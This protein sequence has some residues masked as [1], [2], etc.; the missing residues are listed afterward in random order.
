[1]QSIRGHRI[2]DIFAV[3]ENIENQIRDSFNI[4][5]KTGNYLKCGEWLIKESYLII[6]VANVLFRFSRKKIPFFAFDYTL[7]GAVKGCIALIRS[8]RYKKRTC[9]EAIR[10]K[11]NVR[12]FYVKGDHPFCVKILVSNIRNIG[13]M[14]TEI[15]TRKRVSE[16]KVL[17]IPKIFRFDLNYSPSFFI[18]E[19]VWGDKPIRGK[20]SGKIEREFS[21][22]IWEMYERYGITAKKIE[23]ILDV[24]K[25][26]EI[27]YKSADKIPWRANYGKKEYFLETAKNILFSNGYLQYSLGH[28]DLTLGN[29]I[30]STE[31]SVYLVDWER[32]RERAIVFDSYEII[33]EIPGSREFFERKLLNYEEN[34][35]NFKFIPFKDQLKLGALIKIKKWFQNYPTTPAV[36]IQGMETRISKAISKVIKV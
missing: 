24:G 28:G 5:E 4:K 19:L 36:K 9:F 12:A 25:F 20:D 21:K 6:F 31:G 13:H 32:A 23:D 29:I 7:K 2:D 3:L 33:T 34:N 35:K 17:N 27:L 11:N 15:E 22:Q 8:Q 10:V 26:Y 1:M 18:E 14:K 30:I 16:Y